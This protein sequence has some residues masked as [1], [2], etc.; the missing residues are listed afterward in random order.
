MFQSNL[1]IMLRDFPGGLVVKNLPPNAGDVGSIPV[2]GTKIP[3]VAGQLHGMTVEPEY[4]N[5]NQH[6][7]KKSK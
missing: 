7:Q 1:I 4:H 6:S 5:E 2:W 3:L